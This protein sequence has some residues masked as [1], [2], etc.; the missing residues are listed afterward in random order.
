MATDAAQIYNTF[1]NEGKM[2]D[3][4]ASSEWQWLA[5]SYS[6]NNTNSTQFL[7]TP[8]K[9]QFVDYHNAYLTIPMRMYSAGAAWTQMPLIA[10]KQS[11]LDIIGNLTIATDQGQTIVNEMNTHFINNLRM[12]LEKN[13]Q[14][15]WEDGSEM[16]YAP[17]YFP[18]NGVLSDSASTSQVYDGLASVR[19]QVS[20]VNLSGSTV[21]QTN[22]IQDSFA[23]TITT[24]T[25]AGPPVLSSSV[26]TNGKVPFKNQ[27][28]ADRI[29]IIRDSLSIYGYNQTTGL[30]NGWNP[31]GQGA[32]NGSI[33]FTAVIPLKYIHDC[34]YTAQI[35]LQLLAGILGMN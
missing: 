17:D 5:D 30:P 10:F 7:T 18:N 32:N 8:L 20:A 23:T 33:Q 2:P 26:T 24:T 28:F 25:S 4:F 29:T 16:A 27:G 19:G 34:E 9:T 22:T 14:W 11:V 3:Q 6:G 12:R 21:L 31:S 1:H 13:L 35:Q 15:V